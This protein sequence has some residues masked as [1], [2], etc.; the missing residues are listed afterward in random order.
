MKW[1]E[2]WRSCAG[3]SRKLPFT[4]TITRNI[5]RHL[6]N[7]LIVLPVFFASDAQA[8]I[9]FV[10]NIATNQSN[11]TGTSLAVTVPST[12]VAVG[13]SIIISLAM[14]PASG[15]VSCTDTHGNSYV[16]DKDIAN[17]SGTSGVRTVILSAHNVIALTSG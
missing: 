8:Q 6:L 3:R 9:A 15:T 10:K 16:V 17:G 1:P 13:H 12:G 11:S 7:F 14:D 5:H 2:R 4:R